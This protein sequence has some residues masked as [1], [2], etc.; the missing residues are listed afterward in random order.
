MWKLRPF[1]RPSVCLTVCVSISLSVC[2][3]VCL[4]VYDLV[5]AIKSCRTYTNFS[6]GVLYRNLS[7]RRKFSEIY[8]LAVRIYLEV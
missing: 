2:M 3:S 7:N 4:S 6:I 1:F 8:S 5:S